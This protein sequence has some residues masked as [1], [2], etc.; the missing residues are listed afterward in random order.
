M[1]LSIVAVVAALSVVVNTMK[2]DYRKKRMS[3]LSLITFT[4]REKR[5]RASHTLLRH[6]GV[7]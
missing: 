5:T 1:P 3:H 6:M 7:K 2:T 4:Y